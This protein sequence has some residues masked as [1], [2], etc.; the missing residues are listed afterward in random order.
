MQKTTQRVLI[1]IYINSKNN[2][3]SF[4]FL[5]FFVQTEVGD[6]I[7]TNHNNWMHA[8]RRQFIIFYNF[9][10]DF[11]TVQFKLHCGCFLCIGKVLSQLLLCIILWILQMSILVCFLKFLC[12]LCYHHMQQSVVFRLFFFFF[13]P[14]LSLEDGLGGM[15]NGHYSVIMA[16]CR[17]CLNTKQNDNLFDL[18]VF[19][20]IFDNRL[21]WKSTTIDLDKMA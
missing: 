8:S 1:E 5:L 11:D 10:I 9:R 18:N 6:R 14:S 3:F 16:L 4:F 20:F 17:K 12:V 7:A 19:F 2:F 21:T 13:I 15:V